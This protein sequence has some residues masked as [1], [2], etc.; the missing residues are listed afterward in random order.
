M[1]YE[2]RYRAPKTASEMIRLLDDH[3]DDGKILAGGTDLLPNIRDG[4]IRPAV[5]IDAKKIQ[6]ADSIAWSASE[7]LV[8]GNAVTINDVL[9]C[10]EARELFPVLCDCARQLA[11]HQI[12]NRATVAGN[13]VNASP[14]ADMAPALLCL[15]AFAVLESA[16]GTRQVP[17]SEFF[18]GVKHTVLKAGEFLEKIIIPASAAGARGY[19]LKL[20][21]IAGH[22][23]GIIGVLMVRRN[24][25][26]RFGVSSAA[27]TPVLV[28]GM[29]D[30]DGVDAAI[31]KVLAAIK[32]IDDIRASGEYRA[33][34]A[35]T[36]IRRLWQEIK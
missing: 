26:I 23:L 24:N 21:R 17:F 13:V 28:D 9:R 35:S 3:R 18:T 10:R 8:M 19:Y 22:D 15:D 1:L 30:K 2:F 33:F 6:S 29:L 4:N 36:Y 7:G 27:P 5:V 20:K 14:C 25:G 12:R 34:M 16:S 11:S 32:P 31:V